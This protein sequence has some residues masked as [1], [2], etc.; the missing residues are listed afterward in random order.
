[1]RHE[2]TRNDYVPFMEM[3]CVGKGTLVGKKVTSQ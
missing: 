2:F 3:S 1:M